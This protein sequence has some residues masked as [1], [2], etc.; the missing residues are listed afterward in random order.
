M[1]VSAGAIVN[2]LAGVGIAFLIGAAMRI[3]VRFGFAGLILLGTIATFI[4]VSLELNQDVPT[5]GVELFK[6][7]MGEAT[8][9]QRAAM[10][11]EKQALVSILRFYK[12]CGVFLVIVGVAGFVWEQWIR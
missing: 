4:C 6:S 5:W 8:P 9:A 11:E 1:R 3:A 2:A 7:R 10:R 12:W